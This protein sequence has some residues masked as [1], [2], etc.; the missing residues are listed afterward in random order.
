MTGRKLKEGDVFN[1]EVIDKA[2]GKVIME[3]KNGANGNITFT[4]KAGV[5]LPKGITL[6]NGKLIYT[7]NYKEKKEYIY[8][9]LFEYGVSGK[10]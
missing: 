5:T 4:G 2:S 6:E 8:Y 9:S 7:G 10:E 3:G 1:F